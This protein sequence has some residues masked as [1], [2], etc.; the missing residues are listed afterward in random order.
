MQEVANA[1]RAAPD[2]IIDDGS[3]NAAHQMISFE[4]LWPRLAPGGIYVIEDLEGKPVVEMVQKMVGQMHWN[5]T[6]DILSVEMQYEAAVFV[7]KPRAF[8][9]GW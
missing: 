5:K 4:E 7:K 8:P 9:T 3:H 2:L 1:L 6:T